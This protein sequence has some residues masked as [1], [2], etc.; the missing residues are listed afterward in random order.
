MSETCE[1]AEKKRWGKLSVFLFFFFG[2]LLL[3][4][5]LSPFLF[6]AV[7]WLTEHAPSFLPKALRDRATIDQFPRYFD[8]IRLFGTLCTLP[9]FVKL[10]RIKSIKEIGFTRPVFKYF[11][12][13]LGWGLLIIALS[14]LGEYGVNHSS[15]YFFQPENIFYTMG[16]VLL[17]ALVVAFIEETLFR[18]VMLRFFMQGMRPSYA[19]L[20]GA[21]FFSYVHFTKVYWGGETSITWLSGFTVAWKTLFSVA[22]TIQWVKFLNLF[23]VGIFLNLVLLESRSIWLC[24]GIHASWIFLYK[25]MNIFIKTDDSS[26]GSYLCYESAITLVIIAVFIG[27]LVFWRK[28]HMKTECIPAG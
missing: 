14:G 28:K 27:G 13:G 7:T 2:T 20:V 9:L 3:A 4:A 19:I 22:Y 15:L 8:R 10:C 25:M 18:G 1:Q 24:M 6:K 26:F 21:F 5:V 11:F 23:L 17:S 16:M 12:M